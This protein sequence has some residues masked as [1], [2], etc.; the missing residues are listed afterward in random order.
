MSRNRASAK[1]A[2]ARGDNYKARFFGNGTCIVC[3]V[4]IPKSKNG[5]HAKHCS[6]ECINEA[7]RIKRL[8]MHPPKQR[9]YPSLENRLMERVDK[10]PTCWIFTGS[11]NNSGYGMIRIDQTSKRTMLTHRAAYELFV[12]PISEGLLIRHKCDNP[13]CCN[14]DHLEP[15]TAKDNAQDAV[16]RGQHLKGEAHP[17]VVLMDAQVREIRKRYQRFTVPGLRGY[18]S[19]RDELAAE[20]GVSGKYIVAIAAGRERADVQ[21]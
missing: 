10:T 4:P 7:R 1:A 8:E 9:V 20:Y 19:N 11:K 16:E 18:R 17:D 21:D 5:R 12:G 15:G 13:P 14:P 2:G 3:H 6:N